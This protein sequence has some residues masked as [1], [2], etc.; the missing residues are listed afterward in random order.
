MLT[1]VFGEFISL[2]Q[3]QS[4]L[5][6]FLVGLTDGVPVEKRSEGTDGPGLSAVANASV[7]SQLRLALLLAG[8]RVPGVSA[9][10]S[11]E[12][13]RFGGI[14]VSILTVTSELARASLLPGMAPPG[15]NDNAIPTGLRSFV[16]HSVSDIPR[17]ASMW[18][19]AAVALSGLGG[20][21]IVTL[22]GVRIGYRQA[23][24]AVELRATG[25]ARFAGAGPIGVVRSGSF[26]VVRPRGL[27][28][29][30]TRPLSAEVR[31]EVA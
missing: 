30:R 2:T 4:D 21:V 7:A 27:R 19:L 10:A 17:A 23:K 16:P 6:S 25:I 3:L 1:T 14:G 9:A 28:V 8:V 15:P 13:A 20:L 24:A 12:A 11:A 18:A 22:A 5:Y 31:L 26:V 29:T